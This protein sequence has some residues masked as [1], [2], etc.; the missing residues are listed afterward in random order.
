MEPKNTLSPAAQDEINQSF[1]LLL[2]VVRMDLI[3]HLERELASNDLGISFT[4]YR[5]LKV[6]SFCEQISATELA[7]RIDHDAG[8]LTR[9][10]DKMQVSGFVQRH[11]CA[12]DRR[13]VE[14]SLTDAGRALIKPLRNISERLTDLAFRDLSTDERVT[15]MNLLKRVRVTL[16]N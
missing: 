15:L 5:V 11:A 7:R 6:L 2:H 8:A 14:I 10:L 1:G 16:E 13:A 9:L 12:E 3:R 4:Q